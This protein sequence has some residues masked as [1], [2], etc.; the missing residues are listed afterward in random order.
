MRVYLLNKDNRV[1]ISNPQRLHV[2]RF[3]T[4]LFFELLGAP[5]LTEVPEGLANKSIK[6]SQEYFIDLL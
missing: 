6:Y 3:H 4:T 1:A 2:M 5:R